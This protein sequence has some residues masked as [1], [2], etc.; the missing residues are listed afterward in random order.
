MSRRQ[1]L[2]AF[3]HF[4]RIAT[5][6][7]RRID[8]TLTLFPLGA[9]KSEHFAFHRCAKSVDAELSDMLVDWCWHEVAKLTEEA[10]FP[11]GKARPPRTNLTVKL[12]EVQLK[13]SGLRSRK[14][15]AHASGVARHSRAILR[16]RNRYLAHNDYATIKGRRLL[17]GHSVDDVNA[18]LEHLAGFV[19]EAER[20]IR[21]KRDHALRRETDIGLLLDAVARGMEFHSRA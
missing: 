19:V 5:R 6:L 14:L 21:C 3:R 11:Q 9:A 4:R 1:L 18:F 15:R 20:V 13:N 12:I 10:A 2:E 17:G 7:L 16:A 8:L